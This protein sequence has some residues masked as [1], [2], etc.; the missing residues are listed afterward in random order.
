VL[1]ARTDPYWI[2]TSN[3][4]EVLKKPP[5]RNRGNLLV[6]YNVTYNVDW[7]SNKTHTE[8]MYY[9]ITW[10]W[11]GTL[12]SEYET[13]DPND[14]S[15][16]WWWGGWCSADCKPVEKWA[17]SSTYNW[18]RVTTLSGW[19]HLCKE[20]TYSSFNHDI[21]NHRWTWKCN[22][23]LGVWEECSAT[24]PYCGDGIKDSWEQCDPNDPKE[25]N[26]WN[27]W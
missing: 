14:S 23:S 5:Q 13:C 15:Q 20:W 19:N 11:D 17:C 18:Q 2:I 22:N 12:D 26:F 7:W 24:E 16:T 27:G 9:E 21:V 1:P 4:Y 25:T 8:C 10:C 3:D 6:K